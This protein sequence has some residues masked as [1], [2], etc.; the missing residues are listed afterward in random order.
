M[1]KKAEDFDPRY[2][3][4]FAGDL[5][6]DE[7]ISTEMGG[8]A[9]VKI[10][11]VKRVKVGKHG[12]AKVLFSGVNLKTQ[13]NVEWTGQQTT[14]LFK[15]TPTM[16]PCQLLFIDSDSIHLSKATDSTVVLEIYNKDIAVGLDELMKVEET[17]EEGQDLNLT[18]VSYPA[19]HILKE[20]RVYKQG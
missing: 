8:D 13:K 2:S 15:L 14:R 17:L 12:S 10:K 7:I 20:I 18:L 11:E 5:K 6:K 1:A 3:G 19:F 16:E 9:Y 4:I